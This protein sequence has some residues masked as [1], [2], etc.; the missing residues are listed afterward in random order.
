MR[1][2]VKLRGVAALSVFANAVHAQSSLT[3]YGAIDNGLLYQSTSASSFSPKAP[4]NGSIWQNKD[5]GLYASFWGMRVIED[6]GGGYDVNVKLQGAFNSGNGK[7]QLSDTTGVTAIFNQ[8][9]SVGISGPFGTVNAGRQYSPMIYAMVD[10]DVRAGAYFGSILTA[11]LSMN[12]AAGWSGANSNLPIGALFD[13]NAVVYQSPKFY[14][15][16]LA[17]EYALGGV[18]GQ[19]QGGSRESAVIR[20]SNFGLNVSAVYYN[21]HDTNPTSTSIPTGLNNNRFYYLGAMYR[22][23]GASVSASYSVGKNPSNSA[24]V[25]IEM[26]SGGLGYQFNPWFSVTS[27]YYYLRDRNNSANHSSA[28]SIG[29]DYF[30]SKRTTAYLQ[31]GYVDNKGTMSQWIAYGAPVA[32]GVSTTEAMIGIRH[33]F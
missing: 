29:A 4:D 11:W 28:Y 24:H 6:I 31:V 12:Q 23:L 27:G 21:G 13:S 10:T 5:A 18:A 22:Y 19:A 33:S 9:A 26:I 2:S 16:S 20:Y 14:G 7:F 8:V 30:L 32:P 3:L 25:D 1:W 15:A 17:L